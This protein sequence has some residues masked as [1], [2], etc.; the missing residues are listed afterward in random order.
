MSNCEVEQISDNLF[1][2]KICNFEHKRKFTRICSPLPFQCKYTGEVTG[3]IDKKYCTCGNRQTD[4]PVHFCEKYKVE[5]GLFS[6]LNYYKK[7][8]ILDNG[9]RNCSDCPDRFT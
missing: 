9:A 1:R 4:F 6:M 2:C 8:E 3:K 7:K 5:C